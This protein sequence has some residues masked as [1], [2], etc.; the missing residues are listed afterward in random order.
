MK[1]LLVIY[2]LIVLVFSVVILSVCKAA[3][4][5]P[6]P[7]IESEDGSHNDGNEI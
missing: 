2:M 5:R 7:A 1:T 3:K 4:K 6:A